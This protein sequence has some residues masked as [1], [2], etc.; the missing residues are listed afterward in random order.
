LKDKLRS[1]PGLIPVGILIGIVLGFIYVGVCTPT[2]AAALGAFGAL[3]ITVIQRGF[4]WRLL[5]DS[6]NDTMYACGTLLIIAAF[7]CICGW[8]IQYLGITSALGEKISEVGASPW[9]VL[10]LVTVMYYIMGCLVDPLALTL[11]SI[12]VVYPLMTSVGWDP[13]W[14]GVYITLNM[15]VA[16]ITPPVGMNLYVLKAMVPEA[17][18]EDIALGAAPY[19]VI[20]TVLL[21]LM[22][23]FPELCTWLPSTMK[24]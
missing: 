3:V 19:V 12:P 11:I 21:V 18:F 4:S 22:A 14:L 23:V 7:A 20:A 13:I 16:M 8:G 17:R 24:M 6:L 5:N 15:E 10:L 1:I 9:L 2:E